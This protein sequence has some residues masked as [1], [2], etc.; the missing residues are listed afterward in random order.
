MSDTHSNSPLLG[1]DDALQLA[2]WDEARLREI[3]GAMHVSELADLLLSCRNDDERRLLVEYIPDECLGEVLLE[4]PEGVQ[5]EVLAVFE[6][7]EIEDVV[8]HLDS[9]DAADLLQA[10]DKEIADEVIG[11]LDPSERRDIAQLLSHDEETAGG[12][13]QSELF[14]V[15]GSWPVEKVLQVLRRFGRE[16][17]N[18]N[19][20]Y[21]VDDDDLL[22]GVLSLHTLLFAEPDVMISLLARTDFPRVMAGQDQEEVARLFEKYD[23]L[24]MPVVNA[25]GELIGRITADDVIDVMREEATEDMYRLAALSDQ[26]DL[27]ESVSTT[28]RRR[29][30]W[31]AVN[32]LTAI[33]ASVVIS[34]FEATIA[35]VVALA[36]LMPIVASMGGIAGTQTLTV[37]VR[38]I[39]LGRITFANARRALIKEVSVGLVSGG[40]FAVVMAMVASLWFPD[41]GL[42]LGAIIAVAMMVNLFAA[43]LAGSV[44][45][46]T[47]QRLDIDPALASGTILTTVTD[48]VGFFTFLGLA[49]IFLV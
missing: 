31:L 48:V 22:V 10:V 5:E 2:K 24:A 1:S 47:L 23:V 33:A 40:V 21:V 28:A 27:A 43:G 44:I 25:S 46:L 7:Q 32:L 49:T 20:V 16:I 17:E 6:P 39:A 3:L 26:D 37:I 45:P 42:R 9:D 38:G 34:Q 30:I 12:L 15:R 19:Y 8:E 18:L 35:K 14:K 41:L 13:M 4:L 11:R 36:V 29:G